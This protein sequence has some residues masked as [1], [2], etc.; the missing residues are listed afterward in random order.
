M[1]NFGILSLLPA[2]IVI[3]LAIISKRT[4]EPLLIGCVAS[5]VIIHGVRF[6][7]PLIDCLFTVVT[8]Y[9]NVWLNTFNSSCL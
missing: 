5:Y 1:E 3:V 9:D 7:T 8:D 4:T 6:I 2:V